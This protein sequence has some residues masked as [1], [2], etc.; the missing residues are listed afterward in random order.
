MSTA[1]DGN[2]LYGRRYRII[3][4]TG[5]GNG[6]DVSKLRCSFSIEKSMAET[7]NYSEVAIYNLS[8]QTEN[9]LI[10]T[11]ERIV[12]EAGYEGN[13]YGLIFDGDIVQPLR[14]KEDGTTYKLT[15]ISQD[16]DLFLNGGVVNASFESG[17]TPR[18]IVNQITLK[19][20][21]SIQTGDISENLEDKKLARGKVVFGLARDYLRQISKS[22]NATFYVN[23]RKAEIVKPDDA[24]RGR[25][26]DLTAKSGLIG[27]PE[28]QESGVK[29][30]CLLN[31]F[32]NLN[33]F[34]HIDN[35]I[36]RMEKIAR[37]SG[38]KQLDQD[39]V[40]RIIKI[41]HSG[42]T[43]GDTWYTDFVGVSQYADVKA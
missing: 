19:A 40:Y 37:D 32:L 33:S 2:M 16:G 28:Q 8:P 3:V 34:V 11:G 7:P 4:G 26:I 13:Q 1:L 43:R 5:S 15:L 29:G 25:I 27:I 30:K 9:T 10:K 23:D 20:S 18:N 31:P 6:I 12:I 24:P 17:Q 36:V 38:I 14:E 22:E 42:D 39:G 41:N 35:S 21:E